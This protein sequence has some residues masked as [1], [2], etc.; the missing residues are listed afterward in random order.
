MC[1][2]FYYIVTH[3]QFAGT[4]AE[5]LKPAKD[6]SPIEYPRPDGEIS[7]D[8][9]TSVALTNTNH[10]H[11]QPPHL[12][13]QDDRVPVENNL[14]V[15]GGPEGRFCPAGKSWEQFLEDIN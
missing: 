9:L 15:F 7:F 6:C 4:D 2:L 8:L 3:F 5:S 1:L 10:D 11:D 12:T 14:K 13:L